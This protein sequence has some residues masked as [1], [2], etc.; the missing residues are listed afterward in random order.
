AP[1][2]LPRRLEVRVGHRRIHLQL[3]ALAVPDGSPLSD[4]LARAEMFRRRVERYADA[5]ID[6]GVLM[7]DDL[8]AAVGPLGRGGTAIANLRHEIADDVAL[9]DRGR[10]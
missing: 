2:S 5:I 3:V 6:P 4:Q 8:E 10:M 1:G 7:A 9:S